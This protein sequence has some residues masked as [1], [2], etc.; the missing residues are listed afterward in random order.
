MHRC[1]MV[2][3]I[4]TFAHSVSAQA[5]SPITVDPQATKNDIERI[6][7]RAMI[8]GGASTFLETLTD[9]IG[10]RITGSPQSR[11]TADLILKTLK[12]SGF[13]NAHFENYQFSPTWQ[14][15]TTT[16]EVVSPVRRALYVGTYGW[17]PGTP[18]PIEVPVAQ[19]G[20]ITDGHSPI[21]QNLGG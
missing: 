4:L 11:A 6:V 5:K 12:E 2:F 3:A 1:L 20:A 10:G 19:L 7:G 15:G 21:S 17:V 16:S 13:D 8:G 9:T 18:G 14:K